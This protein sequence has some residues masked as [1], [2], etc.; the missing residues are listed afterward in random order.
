M[1]KKE[2]EKKDDSYFP[3][4]GSVRKGQTNIF[5]FFRPNPQSYTIT[6][7]LGEVDPIQYSYLISCGV[8]NMNCLD[9]CSFATLII[10]SILI[11]RFTMSYNTTN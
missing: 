11:L 1:K 7:R 8:R 10:K 6:I 9:F 4:F 2:R 5:F 3:N